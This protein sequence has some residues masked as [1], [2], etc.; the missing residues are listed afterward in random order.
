MR[1]DDGVIAKEI[2]PASCQHYLLDLRRCGPSKLGLNPV[3]ANQVQLSNWSCA[4]MVT[5]HRT[6]LCIIL[7]EMESD[8]ALMNV[9]SEKRVPMAVSKQDMSYLRGRARETIVMV[10]FERGKTPKCS[11]MGVPKDGPR[12]EIHGYQPLYWGAQKP[13]TWRSRAPIVYSR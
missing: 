9:N 13:R 10:A 12:T 2:L 7:L 11:G 6:T 8:P 4:F 5:D 3:L 1:S